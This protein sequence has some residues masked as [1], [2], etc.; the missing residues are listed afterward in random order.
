MIYLNCFYKLK[1][2]VWFVVKPDKSEDADYCLA[3]RCK[4]YMT[5]EN[6]RSLLYCEYL[7]IG[8]PFYVAAEKLQ[9]GEFLNE[10]CLGCM[11]CQFLTA[12]QTGFYL[13]MDK[14]SSVNVKF[15]YLA[16]DLRAGLLQSPPKAQIPDCNYKCSSIPKMSV[17]NLSQFDVK[18]QLKELS[19]QRNCFKISAET[20]YLAP[21]LFE[22]LAAMI[23]P[24]EAIY[25]GSGYSMLG[26]RRIF[27]DT[28]EDY[29]NCEGSDTH[30]IRLSGKNASRDLYCVLQS[31]LHSLKYKV[32]CIPSLEL[33][34]FAD[35]ESA[36]NRFGNYGYTVYASKKLAD[37]IFKL[38]KYEAENAPDI[39]NVFLQ[40]TITPKEIL[41]CSNRNV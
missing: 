8:K 4:E 38:E 32:I 34:I 11:Y 3:Y 19:S 33:G 13:P 22:K 10:C 37:E 41:T 36:G 23:S 1:D 12:Y 40:A 2:D 35:D 20:F 30:C 5:M 26:G 16:C 27:H 6:T 7:P 25:L 17:V 31:E 14:L 28:A 9:A 24:D 21:N 18:A 29:L 39:G 15:V